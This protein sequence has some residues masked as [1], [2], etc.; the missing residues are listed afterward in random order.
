[1]GEKAA[2]L[3]REDPGRGLSES[4]VKR[5]LAH[6]SALFATQQGK[7]SPADDSTFAIRGEMTA[8]MT[9]QVGVFRLGSELADAV[10]RLGQL[11]ERYQGLS[12]RGGAQPFNYALMD[13]LEVGYLLDLSDIIA[14]GALARTESRGAHYRLDYPERDDRNWL[15]HTFVRM[16]EKGPE[17]YDG[18][19][20]IT[21][22]KPQARG[23]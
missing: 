10:E 8:L 11:K 17:L 20:S 12:L 15:H 2:E 9:N 22:H 18:P 23:Y 3:A 14:R 1:V 5:V 21:R 6:W 13:Y 7:H 16:G 19:V 4:M